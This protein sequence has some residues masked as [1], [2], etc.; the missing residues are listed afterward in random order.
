MV[1]QKITCPSRSDDFGNQ[2]TKPNTK[3]HGF[4]ANESQDSNCFESGKPRSFKEREEQS[5]ERFN[6]R[7]ESYRRIS[8][9]SAVFASGHNQLYRGKQGDDNRE[10]IDI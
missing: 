3:R 2:Y 7:G 9:H 8:K 5:G 6:R 1:A 4:F 10:Y